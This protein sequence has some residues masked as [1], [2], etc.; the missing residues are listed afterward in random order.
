MAI[1]IEFDR[2]CIGD[3]VLCEDANGVAFDGKACANEFFR[4]P[5]QAQG[6]VS[7][8]SS[9]GFAPPLVTTIDKFP[10]AADGNAID[11]GELTQCREFVTGQSSSVSGYSSGGEFNPTPSPYQNTI[12]KY[13]AVMMRQEYLA[14]Q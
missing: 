6:T 12:D 13:Q 14:T 8:Y 5:T 1:K 4:L 7:G 9:G 2:I 11:V 10:F 3:F